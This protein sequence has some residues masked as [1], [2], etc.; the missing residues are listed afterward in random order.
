LIHNVFLINWF[1]ILVISVILVLTVLITVIGRISYFGFK[2]ASI[3]GSEF[4]L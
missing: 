3:E 1:I 4:Y 2:I